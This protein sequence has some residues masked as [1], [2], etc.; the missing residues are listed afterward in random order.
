M[1]IS[2]IN[3]DKI[4]SSTAIFWNE[5]KKKLPNLFLAVR[6]YLNIPASSTF[7]ERFFSIRG[8]ICK[9]RAGAMCDDT[10]IKRSFLRANLDILNNLNQD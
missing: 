5:Q 6:S 7:I 3:G 8:L 10:I 1:F 2:I 4:K 9:K